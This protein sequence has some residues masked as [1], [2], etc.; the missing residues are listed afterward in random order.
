VELAVA[1]L[2]V[3]TAVLGACAAPAGPAMPT[4]APSVAAMAVIITAIFGLLSKVIEVPSPAHG[5]RICGPGDYGTVLR[6]RKD[7]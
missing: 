5:P 1:A 6:L 4:Q 3:V 7:L 2:L